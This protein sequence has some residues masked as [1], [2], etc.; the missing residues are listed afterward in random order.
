MH[1]FIDAIRTVFVRGGGFASVTH[2]VLAL[3]II[4]AVMNTWVVVSY[5]KKLLTHSA[6]FHK[7]GGKAEEDSLH[8]SNKNNQA[9]FVLSLI[10][11]TFATKNKIKKNYRDI[12]PKSL[13]ST[14]D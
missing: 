6:G 3:A 1:Y 14:A 8:F 9:C 12:W 10:C 5:R 11:T 4:V 2:Q 7:I 13:P